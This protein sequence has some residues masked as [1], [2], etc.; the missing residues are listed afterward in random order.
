MFVV[1]APWSAHDA[2]WTPQPVS[3]RFDGGSIRRLRA[4]SGSTSWRHCFS[5]EDRDTHANK[6]GAILCREMWQKT[7]IDVG[8]I[9]SYQT[10]ARCYLSQAAWTCRLVRLHR[11]RWQHCERYCLACFASTDPSSPNI[12]RGWDVSSSESAA[13]LRAAG[14]SQRWWKSF[15]KDK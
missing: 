1:S 2:G 5:C 4:E 3:G 15:T 8:L 6:D 10:E 13:V 11:H 7:N 14:G 9:K 12:K